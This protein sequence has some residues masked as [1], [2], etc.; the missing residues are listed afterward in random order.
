MKRKIARHNAMLGKGAWKSKK[1][2][3]KNGRHP[4]IKDGLGYTKGAK[5]NGS[6]VINRYECVQSMSKEKVGIDQPAQM[7]AQ[8]QPRAA[9]PVKG[10]SAAVTG[11]NAAP[12]EKRRLPLFILLMLSPRRSPSQ[13]KSPR[14]QR[15]QS[16]PL[17]ISI[18]INR[19]PMHLDRV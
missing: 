13:S 3:Y 4:H 10:S 15:I 12:I 7:V 18:L 2:Q 5:T 17:Q 19:R 16:G 6:K 11:G 14:N 1:P 8:K 9:Q